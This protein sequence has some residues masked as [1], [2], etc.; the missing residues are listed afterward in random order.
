[1]KRINLTECTCSICGKKFLAEAIVVFKEVN[2]LTGIERLHYECPHCHFDYTIAVTD[3]R[4][5]EM[6]SKRKN[7]FAKYRLAPTE[8]KYKNIKKLDK[9][10]KEYTAKLM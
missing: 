7:M 1:M 10:I 2:E 6:I 3:E 8:R 9:E 5:R 4:A